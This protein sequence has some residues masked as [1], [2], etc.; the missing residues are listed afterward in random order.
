MLS[1]RQLLQATAS[2]RKR[3]S[4]SVDQAAAK[5][6]KLHTLPMQ[7]IQQVV[8][9]FVPRQFETVSRSLG[10]Q[11]KQQIW[12]DCPLE[13]RPDWDSETAQWICYQDPYT[14]SHVGPFHTPCCIPASLTSEEDLSLLFDELSALSPSFDY[15]H[16][17]I[18]PGP[19]IDDPVL[20]TVLQ[21]GDNYTIGRTKDAQHFE[22]WLRGRQMTRVLDRSVIVA[23]LLNLI[24]MRRISQLIVVK[25]QQPVL[26]QSI[27]YGQLDARVPINYQLSRD[28]LLQLP[29]M[30]SYE[31]PEVWHPTSSLIDW[32]I[33]NSHRRVPD[34]FIIQYLDEHY[35][36]VLRTEFSR[37]GAIR[38]FLTESML[39][40]RPTLTQYLR[41]HAAEW[42][43]NVPPRI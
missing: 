28:G 39:M 16:F 5:R 12:Q 24:T 7:I 6:P 30:E 37:S 27:N 41:L 11:S 21:P 31:N 1:E 32:M 40:K 9:P 3:P 8:L 23:F 15:M 34:E 13:N 17:T 38:R 26:Q 36:R 2:R 42:L 4:M 14:L 35:D 29:I 18:S 33:F 43:A 10:A 25:R 20:K 22:L 19:F